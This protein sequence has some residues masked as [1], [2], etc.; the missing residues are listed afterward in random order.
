SIRTSPITRMKPR[1]VPRQRSRQKPSAEHRPLH[2]CWPLCERTKG[3]TTQR[4][5]RSLIA[6][7]TAAA[8][9]GCAPAYHSYSSS[10]VPCCYT[11]PPPLP[12]VLYDSCACPQPAA[13]P[14]P[15]GTPQGGGAAEP[16]LPSH[17]VTGSPG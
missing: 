12:Y 5:R 16:P 1:S 3:M 7:A 10:C 6:A 11:A 15:A 17:A 2:G 9:A 13:A 8:A 4:F 14:L